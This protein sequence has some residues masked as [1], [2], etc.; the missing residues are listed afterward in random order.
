MPVSQ[1]KGKTRLGG[2]C[3]GQIQPQHRTASIRIATTMAG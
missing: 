2:F 1:Q 3:Q